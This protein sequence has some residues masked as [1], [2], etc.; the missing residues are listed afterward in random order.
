MILDLQTLFSDDQA[1]TTSAV[2]T[3]VI[4]L[5]A[6]GTPPLGGS[7]LVRDIGPGTPIDIL[8]Q[9]TAD[10]GGTSPTLSAVLEMDDN[11]GFASA[12]TVATSGTL[13]S[14]TQGDRLSIRWIPDG[15]SERY[16]RLS[17]TTGGTTPTH[18][19]TA[20][21]ALGIQTRPY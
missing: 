8:I 9:L 10:A 21:I 1:L 12:T 14:G 7:A 11:E 16:I 20:G 13:A 5:G 18:T 15:T 2:S 4:D 3:N 6:T 19:V 17:Y